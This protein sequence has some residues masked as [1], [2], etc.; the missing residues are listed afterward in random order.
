MIATFTTVYKMNSKS[1]TFFKACLFDNVDVVRHF[2]ENG[3][4]PKAEKSYALF[5]ACNNEKKGFEIVKYLV[6]HGADPRE[7]RLTIFSDPSGR[8][9]GYLAE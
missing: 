9:V 6:E 2:V 1:Q 5:M 7:Q 3:A 8:V 4:D